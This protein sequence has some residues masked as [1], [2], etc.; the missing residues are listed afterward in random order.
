MPILP[1]TWG[2][3]EG[4]EQEVSACTPEGLACTSLSA[5]LSPAKG[6]AS[7]AAPGSG[8]LKF[9]GWGCVASSKGCWL[10]GPGPFCLLPLLGWGWGS[11]SFLPASLLTP[12]PFSQPH[13]GARAGRACV[14]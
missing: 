14:Q 2:W 10:W 4:G 7:L 13:L 3:G 1:A 5:P 12:S 11:L 6:V 8:W 9:G